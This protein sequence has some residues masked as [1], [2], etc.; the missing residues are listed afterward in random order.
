MA[1][2]SALIAVEGLATIDR[3]IIG[4]DGLVWPQLPLP[5]M[6]TQEGEEHLGTTRGGLVGAIAR[7]WC[8]ILAVGTFSDNEDGSRLEKRV[9]EAAELGD[10]LGVGMDLEILGPLARYKEEGSLS[11]QGGR[12][13]GATVYVGGGKPAW[14]QCRIVPA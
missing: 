5:L 10:P 2:W 11:I 9:V 14:P 13:I 8:W 6:F 4:P 12:I 1:G 7:R 3:R